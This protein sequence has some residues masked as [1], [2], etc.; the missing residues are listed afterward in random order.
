MSGDSTGAVIVWD[1]RKF[2]R[3]FNL[4]EPMETTLL[5]SADMSEK[6]QYPEGTHSE[7]FG[8]V[9]AIAISSLCENMFI[10][11]ST[12][13]AHVKFWD[14]KSGVLIR[15]IDG[16]NHQSIHRAIICCDSVGPLIAMATGEGNIYLSSPED[17]YY[18]ACQSITTL[19]DMSIEASLSQVGKY[20]AYARLNEDTAEFNPNSSVRKQ[21]TDNNVMLTFVFYDMIRFAVVNPSFFLANVDI[22][23]DILSK[24]LDLVDL[25]FL[26]NFVGIT[27]MHLRGKSVLALPRSGYELRRT[28]FA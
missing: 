15:V 21:L 17:D 4:I 8:E 28:K 22:T 6:E 23:T 19:R 1:L 18:Q 5:M 24:I 3:L 25:L 9:A 11:I 13:G 14:A 27:A 2:K 10:I 12:W 20:I 16:N 26:D 7:T